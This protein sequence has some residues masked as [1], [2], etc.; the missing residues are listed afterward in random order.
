M[1]QL[2]ADGIGSPFRHQAIG[3]QFAA[4]N[5]DKPFQTV[6]F[7]VVQQHY[8][9]ANVASAGI[10][11]AGNQ[12]TYAAVGAQNTRAG[13]ARGEFFSFT[14][15]NIYFV[16][17]DAAAVDIGIINVRRRGANQRNSVA[18]H[19]NIGVGRWATAVDHVLVHPAFEDQQRSFGRE[20]A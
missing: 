4:G 13:H 15:Q 20:H 7:G 10:V 8:S 16:R 19:Q 11:I 14:H 2:A 17:R 5:G 12:R 18:W 3:H 6:A 1:I 9:A